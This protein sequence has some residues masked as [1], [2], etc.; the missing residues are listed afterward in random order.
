[1][2]VQTRTDTLPAAHLAQHTRARHLQPPI[3]L[4]EP[5]HQAQEDT[6]PKE[7]RTLVLHSSKVASSIAPP[8]QPR[9]ILR[10][11]VRW[12]MV[13]RLTNPPRTLVLHRGIT[14]KEPQALVDMAIL[15]QFHRVA[16]MVLRATIKAATTAHTL[17][18]HLPILTP[19]RRGNT[20]NL[21]AD[22]TNTSSQAT[23]RDLQ[24]DSNHNKVHMEELHNTK[25][26][27]HRATTKTSSIKLIPVNLRIIWEPVIPVRHLRVILAG[28]RLILAGDSIC[29]AG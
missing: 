2:G 8:R 20:I 24:A 19:I 28:R 16:T 26:D 17:R 9:I 15:V 7:I 5:R 27:R 10:A 3:S 23:T 25:E 21:L 11:K 4:Q 29:A 14:D 18:N 6:R 22:T 12:A 1:M 13:S